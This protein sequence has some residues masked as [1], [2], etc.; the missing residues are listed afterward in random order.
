VVNLVE[1]AAK[2]DRD[3][4]GPIHIGRDG[5]VVADRGPGITAADIERIFDR[6]YRSDTARGLPA[7]ALGL[8]IVHDVAAAHR[9]TAFARNRVGGGAEF[10]FTIDP[11]RFLPARSTRCR[12]WWTA[13]SPETTPPGR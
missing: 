2:F 8:A 12:S 4:S 10:G 3:P 13:A 5:I 1:N 6:Y 11:A 9:G 7:S